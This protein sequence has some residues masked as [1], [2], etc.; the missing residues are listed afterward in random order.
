MAARP[1]RGTWHTHTSHHRPPGPPRR[2]CR[3]TGEAARTATRARCRSPVWWCPTGRW[4]SA[5]PSRCGPSFPDK[6]PGDS[7]SCTCLPGPSSSPASL[8]PRRPTPLTLL[9]RA[10]GS[11]FTGHPQLGPYGLPTMFR[12]PGVPQHSRPSTLALRHH[13]QGEL[14]RCPRLSPCPPRW[15]AARRRAAWGAAEPGAAAA[16]LLEPPAPH[17][18]LLRHHVPPAVR[19]S[20]SPCLVH[21]GS[22]HSLAPSLAS[23][24][25]DP[26]PQT[27]NSTPTCRIASRRAVQT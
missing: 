10:Q 2:L 12:F 9:S 14:S 6:L 15:R 3:S 21:H 22:G 23:G 27:H 5:R 26:P 19:A 16:S 17:A 18:R 1:G 8:A 11:G 4:R 13:S 25:D 24:F 7:R 20:S